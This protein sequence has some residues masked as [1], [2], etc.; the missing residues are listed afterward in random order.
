MHGGHEPPAHPRHLDPGNSRVIQSI[1]DAIV[2]SAP[3]SVQPL[4][5]CDPWSFSAGVS[6][7][8]GGALKSASAH[9]RAETAKPR[10]PTAPRC[11]P[12]P[13]MP[14]S[15]VCLCLLGVLSSPLFILTSV[16][17]FRKRP[18]VWQH[19]R[20]EV[21]DGLQRGGGWQGGLHSAGE[22]RLLAQQ[23]APELASNSLSVALLQIRG[24][25]RYEMIKR[26]NDGLDLL[27]K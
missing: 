26:I 12:R 27:E 6:C 3:L 14:K 23:N 15:A 25:K 17:A 18:N 10:R 1:D 5:L 8:D 2:S 16:L 20:E 19:H 7:W 13:K 22:Q 4:V 21:Q 9:V 11:R 24:R